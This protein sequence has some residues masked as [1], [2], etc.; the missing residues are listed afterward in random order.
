LFPQGFDVTGVTAIFDSVPHYRGHTH[1]IIDVTRL[2]LDD[3]YQF[4][5]TP[6]TPKQRAP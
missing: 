6:T 3:P 1:V 4:A 5:W 2:Q